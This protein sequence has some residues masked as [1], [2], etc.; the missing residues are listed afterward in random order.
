M[1]SQGLSCSLMAGVLL[2]LVSGGCSLV[3]LLGDKNV[4]G[5]V[6]LVGGPFI[7]LGLILIGFGVGSANTEVRYGEKRDDPW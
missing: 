5:L 4:W 3:F 6:L 1:G 7:L 2:L